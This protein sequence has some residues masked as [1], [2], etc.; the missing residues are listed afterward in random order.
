[1][2]TKEE[3]PGWLH[4]INSGATSLWEAWNGE[5]SYNHPTMGCVG[6]WLYQGLAGIKPDP[7]GPG[8]KKFVIKPSVVG[9]LTWVKAHYDSI[10]GRIESSWKRT[11]NKL[12]MNIT[13]PVNTQA[14]VYIP[15]LG[16]EVI[17][18]SGKPISLGAGIKL[19]P[20]V[21][22]FSVFRVGSGSYRFESTLPI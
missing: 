10:R 16:G 6:F 22:G 3:Y 17:S 19:L 12:E 1:M 13:V 8:Y 18:E 15:S 21:P 7:T 2:L 4:M 20:S 11:G 9:D 14:T 5:G